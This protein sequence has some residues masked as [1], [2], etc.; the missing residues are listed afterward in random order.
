MKENRSGKFF[1]ELSYLNI[2]YFLPD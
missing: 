1:I 2:C